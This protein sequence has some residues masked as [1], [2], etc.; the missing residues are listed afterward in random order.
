M[1]LPVDSQV[2]TPFLENSNHPLDWPTVLYSSLLIQA[3]QLRQ[4]KTLQAS[5]NTFPRGS[6]MVV[7]TALRNEEGGPKEKSM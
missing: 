6:G 3:S 4:I 2:S 5:I 7:R 1:Q